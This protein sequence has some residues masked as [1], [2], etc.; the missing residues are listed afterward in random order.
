M[1]NDFLYQKLDNLD[2]ISLDLSIPKNAFFDLDNTLLVGDIGELIILAMLKEKL[3]LEMNWSDYQNMLSTYGEPHAYKEILRAKKGNTVEQLKELTKNILN[4]NNPYNFIEADFS[5]LKDKPKPNKELKQLINELI[6]RNYNLY[7]ITAGSH[8]VAESVIE[9]WFP[10]ISNLNV[11][12]V[13]NIVENGLLTNELEIPYPINEGKGEVLKQILNG[14][15]AL[16]TV[17]DSPNDLFMFKETHDYGL[18]LIVDHK[19]NKTFKV[20]KKIENLNNIHFI[21]WS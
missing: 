4:D 15:K 16:I 8:F 1:I 6:F 2:K 11:F 9:L 17:G 5:I 12:G 7:V 19:A 21:N 18:K 14:N 20:L 3:N 10:E 13:K